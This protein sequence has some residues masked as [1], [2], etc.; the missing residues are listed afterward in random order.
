M[1][2]TI[3]LPDETKERLDEYREDDQTWAEFL[4]YLL[5]EVQAYAEQAEQ[6]ADLTALGARVKYMDDEQHLA[7]VADRLDTLEDAVQ[8]L[9]WQTAEEVEQRMHR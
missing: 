9:P 4:E 3:T 8:D 5:D 1:A 2:T 6:D 7:E